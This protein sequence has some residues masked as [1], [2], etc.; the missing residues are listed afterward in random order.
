MERQSQH[1][2][3][4]IIGG[5]QAGLATGYYLKKHNID[6]LIL[7]RVTEVG[8]SWSK[9]WDSLRLFTPARYSGLP[10]LSFPG[11]KNLF[12]TKDQMASY[13]KQYA[14]QFDLPVLLGGNI[15]SAERMG[16]HFQLTLVDRCLTCTNLVVATGA[17]PVPKIPVFDQQPDVTI[18]QLHASQYTNP[19][20]ILPG[21]VLVVGAGAS[22]VQMAID[23]A[24]SHEVFLAGKPTFHIP[25]A[26]FKVAGRLYWW[27]INRVL[28]VNT[29]MGRKVKPK[30]LKGGGPL[31]NVSIDDVKAAGVTLLPRLKGFVEGMPQFENGQIIPLGTIIWA[32][33]FRP[34]FSWLKPDVVDETGWPVTK[35]G[36]SSRCTN[37]FFVGMAFQH[38]LASGIIG[39]VGRDAAYVAKAIAKDVKQPVC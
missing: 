21:K 30:V 29:P 3:T 20:N 11:K 16:D 1:V 19:L 31:I 35:R 12:P 25:D 24:K 4:I 38:S 9:R 23:L 18:S 26:V 32:T 15:L 39:G 27:F 2:N 37:L 17:N 7:D 28:T 13:L 33:G 8:Q 10:G 6:F 36:V 5:G 34:D 22:G 14:K